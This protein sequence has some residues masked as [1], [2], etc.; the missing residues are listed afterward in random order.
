MAYYNYEERKKLTVFDSIYNVNNPY[1]YRINVNHP[2]VLPMYEK[3]KATKTKGLSDSDRVD[4]ENGFEKWYKE[5]IELNRLLKEGTEQ[6]ILE[7]VKKQAK[8]DKKHLQEM[9]I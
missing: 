5:D 7:Y 8:P 2:I 1:N 4:F 9:E 6:E 3:Y